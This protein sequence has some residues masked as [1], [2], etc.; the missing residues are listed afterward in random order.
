MTR[1]LPHLSCLL[2][3]GWRSFLPHTCL[4]RRLQFSPVLT[5]QPSF[6]PF[7]LLLLLLLLLAAC[8]SH[9]GALQVARL[10][11][12]EAEL[13]ARVQVASMKAAEAESAVDS[14]EEQLLRV[15]AEARRAQ[16]EVAALQELVS[17]RE[18]QIGQLQG[19]LQSAQQAA[20]KVGR[21]CTVHSRQS[22]STPSLSSS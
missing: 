4:W 16:Q 18:G 15:Q 19:Q 6:N 7:L 5:H 2:E 11:A 17:S 21:S 3:F 20:E 8:C 9:C 1:C 10:Q 14:A 22:R 13:K 12:V